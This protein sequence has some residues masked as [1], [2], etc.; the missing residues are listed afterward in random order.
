MYEGTA[1]EIADFLGIS[2]QTVFNIIHGTSRKRDYIIVPN[3]VH[4]DS[5]KEESFLYVKEHLDRF[6]NT[7]L[8]NNQK[9]VLK[10]LEEENIPVKYYKSNFDGALIIE[11]DNDRTK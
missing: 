8:K 4:L 3:T 1:Y 9:Y 6:G 5:K 2:R 7:C 11:L 10:R